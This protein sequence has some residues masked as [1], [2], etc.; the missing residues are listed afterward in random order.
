MWHGESLD[1]LSA[2]H[3]A[4]A[5]QVCSAMNDQSLEKMR[6][7]Q[8]A[9]AIAKNRSATAA[10]MA[11]VQILPS[12]LRLD[13]TNR[14]PRLPGRTLTIMMNMMGNEITPLATALRYGDLMGSMD[15]KP[16]ATPASVDARS[17]AWSC[18]AAAGCISRLFCHRK[19]NG[20]GL[21]HRCC[22]PGHGEG[23]RADNADAE[24]HEGKL[25]GNGPQCLGR[26]RRRLDVGDA[27]GIQGCRWRRHVGKRDK[28]RRPH[29]FEVIDPDPAQVRPPVLMAEPPRSE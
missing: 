6:R 29:P 15:V 5:S 23:S 18:F 2:Q 16:N 14:F 25:I 27:V 22:E 11:P 21:R 4:A 20:H 17:M 8:H 24:K 19:R 9:S 26:L 28:G 13:F 10:A 12:A 7:T 1:R 3:K